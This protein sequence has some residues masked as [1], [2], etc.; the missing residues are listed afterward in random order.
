MRICY[1][2]QAK[3]S[4]RS[5][6]RWPLVSLPLP[7]RPGQIVSCDLLGPLPETKNGN[8][9]VFSTVDLFNRHADGYA[10]TKD[11]KTARGCALKIVDYIPRWGCPHTFSSDRGAEFISQ[12]SRD[13]YETLETVNKFQSFIYPQT[14]GLVERLNHA[15]CQMLSY[16]IADDQKNWD[17]MLMHA[18]TTLVEVLGRH[19]MKY[20]LVDTH[21]YR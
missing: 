11:E 19:L 12:V 14:N 17:D 10:M 4:S 2:C 15:L 1:S 5:T 7:S 18:V 20:I 6:V 16:L 9:H 13:V 21:G 8:V 3:K